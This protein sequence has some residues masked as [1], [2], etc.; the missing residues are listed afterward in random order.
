MVFPLGDRMGQYPMH[1]WTCKSFSGSTRNSP[2]VIWST[3]SNRNTGRVISSGFLL[4]GPHY[5]CFACRSHYFPLSRGLQADMVHVAGLSCRLFKY[6]TN[7]SFAKSKSSCSMA[8][9][10][11]GSV[12]WT[13]DQFIHR[14][15]VTAV[16]VSSSNFRVSYYHSRQLGTVPMHLN[17]WVLLK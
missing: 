13:I 12:T 7:W 8:L 11:L 10:T 16:F 3:K 15:D 9:S 6:L 4:P 5:Q 14:Q 17:M 2:T 1:P